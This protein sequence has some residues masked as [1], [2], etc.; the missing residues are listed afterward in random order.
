MVAKKRHNSDSIIIKLGHNSGSKKSW[1]QHEKKKKSTS[2]P[3]LIGAYLVHISGSI[4]AIL[5]GLRPH[6]IAAIHPLPHT[7]KPPLT[8]TF[9][10]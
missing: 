10:C 8:T 4:A 5:S 6:T 7:K 1:Y 9:Y 3:P 2:N